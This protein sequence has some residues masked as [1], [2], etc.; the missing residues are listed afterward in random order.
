MFNSNGRETSRLSDDKIKIARTEALFRDVNERI[1]ETAERFEVEDV[2]FVCECANPECTHRVIL[3]P[4]EYEEVRREPARFVTVP[5]HGLG[6]PLE[7]LVD[8]RGGYHVIEKIE[9]VLRDH[10]T[11]LDPR[12]DAA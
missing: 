3:P 7:R 10:V 12:A 8:D 2:Q 11:L 1:A 6:E 4:A 5:G 9:S